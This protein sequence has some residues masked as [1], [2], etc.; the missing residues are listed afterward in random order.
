MISDVEMTSSLMYGLLNL[1]LVGLTDESNTE[2]QRSDYI[3]IVLWFKWIFKINIGC[4][5]S[6]T[7]NIVDPWFTTR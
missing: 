6:P 2:L 7:D 5:S 1:V 3:N 4:F